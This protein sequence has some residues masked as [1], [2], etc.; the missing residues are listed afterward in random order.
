MK[1]PDFNEHQLVS[2]F[3]VFYLAPLLIYAGFFVEDSSYKSLVISLVMFTGIFGS[4]YHSLMLAKHRQNK[5]RRNIHF[6]YIL[7][8]SVFLYLTYEY[9]ATS[10]VSCSVLGAIGGFGIITGLYHGGCLLDI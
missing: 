6:F 3:H 7:V 2:L 10:E 1:L 8:L 4:I 9:F 5:S